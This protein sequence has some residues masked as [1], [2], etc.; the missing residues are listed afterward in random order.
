MGHP[1]PHTLGHGKIFRKKPR[2]DL[3]W[4]YFLFLLVL[5]DQPDGLLPQLPPFKVDPGVPIRPTWTPVTWR[6]TAGPLS[7][8]GGLAARRQ[9]PHDDAGT[10]SICSSLHTH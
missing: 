8:G 2:A 9:Q 6:V 7:G 10:A 3:F 5:T 4:D 1:T